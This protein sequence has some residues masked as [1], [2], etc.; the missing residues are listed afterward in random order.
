MRP[1]HRGIR[2]VVLHAAARPR[3][4]P[5]P[6]AAA[7]PRRRLHLGQP[8]ELL[9]AAPGDAVAWAAGAI[10]SLHS[11][12]LPWLLALPLTAAAF[13]FA[14]RLPTR[15]YARRL[16]SRRARLGPLVYAWATRHAAASH[17]TQTADDVA[18]RIERSTRRI[19]KA[20]GVQRWKGLASL[21]SIGPFIV[22]SEALRRLCNCP[23]GW[24]THVLQAGADP[25]AA[26]PASLF[27]ESLTDG[28]ISWINDLTAADP[29][30]T[31]PLLCSAILARNVWGK[32]S[33]SQ[34]RALLAGDDA[35]KP[36]P[37]VVRVQAA[38]GRAALLLP[39]LPLVFSDLPSAIFVFWAATFALNDLN[40]SVID[41]LVPET[42][43]RLDKP[44]QRIQRI[45]E[46]P[47]LR[48]NPPRLK[49][50]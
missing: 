33:V 48:G 35:K 1:L 36:S 24:M 3:A 20:W 16:T 41:R 19:Y 46:L 7:A 32:L 23:P 27:D 17:P 4:P 8:V 9:A 44:P 34:L 12:G 10:G 14:L 13:N 38:V 2:G 6:R 25:A 29:Y 49:T 18:L 15:Y 42:R 30:C 50:E 47:Y 21:F 28:G 26:P 5:E 45:V 22:V 40:D 37:L 43:P 31:L 39:I 11:F